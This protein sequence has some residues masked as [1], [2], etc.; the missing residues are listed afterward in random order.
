MS[1]VAAGQAASLDSRPRTSYV[2]YS[3]GIIVHYI[4]LAP[5]LGDPVVRVHRAHPAAQPERRLRHLLDLGWLEVGV[6]EQRLQ[7]LHGCGVDVV[8]RKKREGW[9]CHTSC[10]HVCVGV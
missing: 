9:R 6:L 1:S 10:M 8:L 5:H 4:I 3:V 2:Q 7:L